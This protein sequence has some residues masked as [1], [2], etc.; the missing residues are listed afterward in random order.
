MSMPSFAS[1]FSRAFCSQKPMDPSVMATKLSKGKAGFFSESAAR[2]CRRRF[3]TWGPFPWVIIRS[4]P[5]FM[6]FT[7]CLAVSTKAA[8]CAFAEGSDER[9]A[10]PPKATTILR[11][12]IIPTFFFYLIYLFAFYVKKRRTGQVFWL[13]PHKL[14]KGATIGLKEKA[15]FSPSYTFGMKRLPRVAAMTALMVCMRFSA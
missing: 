2:F 6:S 8:F 5:F 7:R 13:S 11:L 14:I 10:L 3:P 12:A 4:S 15:S 1:S 9:M